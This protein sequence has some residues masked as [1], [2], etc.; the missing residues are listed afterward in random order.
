LYIER[1]GFGACISFSLP[2]NEIIP[3][4]QNAGKFKSLNSKTPR[5]ITFEPVNM[6][7]VKAGFNHAQCL[8]FF[9]CFFQ[10]LEMKPDGYLAPDSTADEE[11]AEE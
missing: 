8:V 6:T 3:L 10:R 2:A 7:N 9:C 4:E 11:E 5:G 1:G